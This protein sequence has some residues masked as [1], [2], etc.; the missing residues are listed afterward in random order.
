M[1]GRVA[2]SS[3][4]PWTAGLLLLIMSLLLLPLGD[5]KLLAALS[6][7]SALIAFLAVNLSLIVLRYRL[8]AF[9][10]PFIVPLSIGRIPIL[11]VLAVVSIGIMLAAF[12]RTIVAIGILLVL[13]VLSFAG[14]QYL[15]ELKPGKIRS[16]LRVGR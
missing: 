3:R 16:L 14:R 1:L 6:S 13:A 15:N 11:P 8:P 5:L 7:F 4:T 12:E 2:A 9:R 10:R